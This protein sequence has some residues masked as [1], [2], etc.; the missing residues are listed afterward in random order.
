[1]GLL[2]Y[3]PPNG[4]IFIDPGSGKER[5]GFVG[6]AESLVCPLNSTFIQDST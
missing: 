3:E 5:N 6:L 4:Y 1:M 2:L